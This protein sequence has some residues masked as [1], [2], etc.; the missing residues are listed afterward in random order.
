[1]ITG[2]KFGDISP[3]KGSTFTGIE[4]QKFLSTGQTLTSANIKDLNPKLKHLT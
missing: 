1:L 2:S 3:T 4:L